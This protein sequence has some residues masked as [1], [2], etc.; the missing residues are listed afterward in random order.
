MLSDSKKG[1][2]KQEFTLDWRLFG[3]NSYWYLKTSIWRADLGEEKTI[4][5]KELAVTH[6]VKKSRVGILWVAQ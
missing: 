2:R 1:L 3:C 4:I 6:F 5:V